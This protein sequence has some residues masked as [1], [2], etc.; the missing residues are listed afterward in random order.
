MYLQGD[1]IGT[2]AKINDLIEM[3][4][5]CPFT[6]GLAV[7]QA[8]ALVRYWNDTTFFYNDC[9]I[10]V[11]SPEAHARNVANAL[12]QNPSAVIAELFPNPADNLILA[13]TNLINGTLEIWD[14]MG[15]K[16]LTQKLIEN[17][18]KIDVS[19]F[20]NGTYLYKITD[21]SNRVVKKDKLMI[22]H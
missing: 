14:V 9:E 11:P 17:E 1:S 22:N 10:N 3:A 4:K 15:R 8:R 6:D 7:Y 19:S 18:T 13:K 12:E 20:N 2:Y 16:V 5:L 21:S